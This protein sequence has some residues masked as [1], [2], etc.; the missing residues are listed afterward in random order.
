M[1]GPLVLLEGNE[2]N[3]SF[4]SNDIVQQLTAIERNS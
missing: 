4:E 1:V 3:E 2:S